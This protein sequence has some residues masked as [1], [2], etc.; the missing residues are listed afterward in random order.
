MI[1]SRQR[2]G[3]GF[4]ST[5]LSL[6]L[7]GGCG[8]S[9]ETG[10]DAT[11]SGSTSMSAPAPSASPSQAGTTGPTGSTHQA[12]GV[13]PP[14]ATPLAE[15]VTDSVRP[16]TQSTAQ[17]KGDGG[18]PHEGALSLWAGCDGAVDEVAFDVT[19]HTTFQGS[20]GLRA[21]VP[22]DMRIEVL[23]LTDGEP[24]QNLRLDG[25]NPTPA[26]LPV[27]VLTEGRS[28]VTL[29]TKVVAGTCS[30]AAESYVVLVDGY[31]A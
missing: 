21:N 4:V 15:R 25:T 12:P 28:T 8:V 7:L 9:V 24:V 10:S 23:V 1:T 16:V 29:Q 27:R 2:L 6:G 31:V 14:G 18:G 30:D 20:L 11:T 13:V 26:L 19:G 22:D 5:V 3:L 17:V